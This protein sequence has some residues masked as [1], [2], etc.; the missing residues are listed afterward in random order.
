MYKTKHKYEQY[1]DMLSPY[2]VQKLVNFRMCNNHFPIEKLRLANV[3]RNDIICHIC[4]SGEVGDEFHY[5]F[6]CTFF[7]QIR[8]TLIP[9]R[10]RRNTNCI[11]FQ[12]L[13][14]E[15]M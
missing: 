13:R 8:K 2:Y 4:N 3:Q 7:N 9:E 5:L 1:F 11:S 12:S 6:N 10:Y 14:N 15:K